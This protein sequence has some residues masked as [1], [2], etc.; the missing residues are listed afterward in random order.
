MV[1][2]PAHPAISEDDDIETFDTPDLSEEDPS[3]KQRCVQP[4]VEVLEDE[5]NDH[6]GKDNIY[7][8]NNNRYE[9]NDQPAPQAKRPTKEK[10]STARLTTWKMVDLNNPALPEY[11][12]SS[13]DFVGTHFEYFSRYFSP[14]V[15]KHITYQTTLYATQKDI[16]TTFTTTEDEMLPPTVIF[17]DNFF[18]SLG[19][20]RYLKDKNCSYTTSDDGILAF[21]WKDNKIVTLLSTDMGVDPMSSVHRYY[22]E[23]KQKEEVSCP[24]VIKT[25]NPNMEVTDK[26]DML[27][28]LYHSPMKSK[29]W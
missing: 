13:P 9:D 2:V 25:Y 27:V 16:N 15:I 10:T 22:S 23:T 12:H 20:V 14:Q 28:H 7:D 29:R 1:V 24:A 19:L 4:T 18:T 5:D 21:R 8:H 11:Q 6:D 26:S 3:V 17:A